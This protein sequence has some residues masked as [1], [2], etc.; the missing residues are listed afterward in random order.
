MQESAGIAYS[1]ISSNLDKYKADP[2]FFD[3]AF[4]HMHVPDGATPKDGP[5]AGITMATSLLSLARQEPIKTPLAMTGELSLTGQVLPVGGIRE[6][7]VAARRLGIKT[8]IIPE[9]N[10]KD[11]NELPDY[12]KQGM[13]LHFAKHFDDV[14]RLTFNIRSQSPA[15]KAHLQKTEKNPSASSTPVTEV[16]C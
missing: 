4:V 12:L 9:D 6:K 2:E 16:N 15:Y 1:F 7:V 11:Y 8:L 13:T 3:K 14:A 10:T 5:S